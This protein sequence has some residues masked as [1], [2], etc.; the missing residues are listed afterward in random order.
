VSP[1]RGRLLRATLPELFATD[2]AAAVAVVEADD[3]ADEADAA[4]SRVGE[5]T[6]PTP[7]GYAK[8][9]LSLL[10][11]LLFLPP[12]HRVQKGQAVEKI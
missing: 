11:F 5:K 3:E 10:F 7:T 8:L 2:F 4:S 1:E 9:S 12:I 6:P